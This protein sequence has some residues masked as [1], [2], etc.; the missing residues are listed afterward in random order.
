MASLTPQ[1]AASLAASKA[2]NARRAALAAKVRALTDSQ[3]IAAY[4]SLTDLRRTDPDT[5]RI[6]SGYLAAET[7]RRANPT[8]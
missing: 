3:L 4:A 5:A 2:A 8:A 1:Q 7:R 6:L